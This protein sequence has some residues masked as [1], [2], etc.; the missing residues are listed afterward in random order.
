MEADE[1]DGLAAAVLGD[2][3]E[4]E[5]AEKAGG[6]GEFR[7]DVGKA[8]GFDGVDFDCAFFHAVVTADFNLRTHPDAD[9]GGDSAA[10]DAVAEAFGE[11]HGGRIRGRVAA[12]VRR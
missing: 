1:V 2:F 3:E 11:E 12:M 4:I 9:A 5:D 8:N 7:R 10:A 6:A